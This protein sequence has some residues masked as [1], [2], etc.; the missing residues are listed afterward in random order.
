MRNK[1]G[2]FKMF[3]YKKKN[4]SKRKCDLKVI[5]NGKENLRMSSC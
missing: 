5:I 4:R 2:L 1:C 3:D